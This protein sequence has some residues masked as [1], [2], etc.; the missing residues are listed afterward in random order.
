[1]EAIKS[2]LDRII[3][4]LE[5]AP[6]PG[7]VVSKSGDIVFLNQRMRTLV[8]MLDENQRFNCGWL[9]AKNNKSC[10]DCAEAPV[11]E[12]RCFIPRENP[13]L[14]ILI[15][16]RIPLADNVLVRIYGVK[17]TMSLG[18][19]S[20]LVSRLIEMATPE[21]RF[22]NPS[23]AVKFNHDWL[24]RVG[25]WDIVESAI[26]SHNFET[27][28]I[29]NRVDQKC[30]VESTS[31]IIIS[32]V[33]GKIFHELKCVKHRSH[34]LI[35]N[36]SQAASLNIPD[37][38][39]LTFVFKSSKTL[40]KAGA[41]RLTA[42]GL[43]LKAFCGQLSKTSGYFIPELSLFHYDNVV[44]LRF[45][46]QNSLEKAAIP[47]S[48]NITGA[49]LDVSSREQEIVEMVKMGYDNDIISRSLG[50]TNATVKQHLKAVYRKLDVK[51]RIELIFKDIQ[52]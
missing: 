41:S 46:V 51:N 45:P 12:G 13:D 11:L 23:G 37:T 39:I 28:K 49:L 24:C 5:S 29:E 3:G 2:L 6:L 14:T 34:V 33:I 48:E 9:H 43:R 15:A 17:S 31:P 4:F 19:E 25:L 30:V 22:G 26:K 52:L 44:E 18:N 40:G 27:E 36:M 47:D 35:R 1:M 32:Q 8:N 50:I 38:H 21:N 7:S 42:A 10:P 16:L 20:E